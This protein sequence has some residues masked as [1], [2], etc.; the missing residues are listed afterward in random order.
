MDFNTV[1]LVIGVALAVV[2]FFAVKNK[3]HANK[4]IAGSKGVVPLMLQKSTQLK[5]NRLQQVTQNNTRDNEQL[6]KLVAAYKN[7][8][9]NINDYNDKLD[10]MI[11]RLD[12]DL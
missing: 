10:K 9:I 5:V 12:I 8:L 6:L 2:V 4:M 11:I 7:N 3:R 1:L